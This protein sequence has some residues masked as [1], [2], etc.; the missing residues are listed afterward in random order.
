MPSQIASL[1]VVTGIIALFIL[2][3]RDKQRTAAALWIPVVYFS[4]IA[5]R[6][7]SAWLGSGAASAQEIQDGSPVDATVY[8]VLYLLAA[9][10]LIGR[11]ARVQQLLRHSVPVLIFFSYCLISLMWSDLPLLALKRW[12]KL[13]GDL[14]MVLVVVSDPR[15]VAALKRFIAWPAFVLFPLSVLFIKYYPQLGRG[16][17]AWS[18]EQFF[19]GASYNKNGLGA[20]CL[21]W[22][23]GSVWLLAQALTESPRK[24]RPAIV[25]ATVLLMSTWLLSQ[26]SSATSLSCLLLGTTVIIITRI[27]MVSRTPA[28]IHCVVFAM[29]SI[30]FWALFIDRSALGLLQRDPTLTG[31]TELWDA[32]F[33]IQINP[34]VGT[35]YESFWTGRRIEGLWH[36][37]WWRPTQAHNGF[38]E[39]FINLGSIGLALVAMMLFVAYSRSIKAVRRREAW[40]GLL[41]AYVIIII[42]YNFTEATIRVQ[43]L[44]WLFLLLALI[45]IPV[46]RPQ[47]KV[48]AG[49]TD[50]PTTFNVHETWSQSEFRQPV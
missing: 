3:R 43:N 30:S 31:R 7:V 27:R 15:P 1:V 4:I 37:F 12:A 33:R 18:G 49:I 42:P 20:L 39:I 50:T 28:I 24:H 35:G 48:P 36:I 45:G 5:S 40:G 41:L 34:L 9:I 32:I 19:H 2:E 26:S 14:M 47:P 22:G 29:I 17:D 23:L 38:I 6:P 44:P 8:A 13:L 16:Y 10:V 46:S 21:Y 25:A 11:G